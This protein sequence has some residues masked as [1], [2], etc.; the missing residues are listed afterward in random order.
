MGLQQ[1]RRQTVGCVVYCN[2][3]DNPPDAEFC[4]YCGARIN[5]NSAGVPTERIGSA[6]K[7]TKVLTALEVT[8]VGDPHRVFILMDSDGNYYNGTS[9]GYTVSGRRYHASGEV[10]VVPFQNFYYTSGERNY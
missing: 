5:Q 1:Q 6:G 10:L 9:V 4:I 3:T 8:A 2:P 7:V